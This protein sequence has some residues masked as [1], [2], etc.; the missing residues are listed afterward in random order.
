MAYLFEPM[1]T[2]ALAGGPMKV[3]PSCARRSANCAFSLRKPYPGWTA[4]SARTYSVAEQRNLECERSPA[5][6]FD[7]RLR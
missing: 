7:G 1:L 6:R 4:Y 3:I 5:L 2:M